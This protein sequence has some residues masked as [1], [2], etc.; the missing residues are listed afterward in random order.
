MFD[1]VCPFQWPRL[2]ISSIPVLSIPEA[3]I[4]IQKELQCTVCAC[5]VFLSLSIYICIITHSLV[6]QCSLS[7]VLQLTMAPTIPSVPPC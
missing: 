2:L 4:H 5:V 6:G 3:Q 1:W 7:C